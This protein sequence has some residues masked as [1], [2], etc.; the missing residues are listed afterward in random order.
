MDQEHKRTDQEMETEN[1]F[2][3]MKLMLEK[4][5]EFGTCADGKDLPPGIENEFLKHIMEFEKQW[6]DAPMIKIYDKVGRPT[7]F[8]PVEAIDEENIGTAWQELSAYLREHGISLDACSPNITRRELYRFATQELFELEVEDIQIPGL[9]HGFIYDEFHPDPVYDN[10]CLA[11][12]ECMKLIFQEAPLEW[13][14]QFSDKGIRLNTKES[15]TAEALRYIINR[16]KTVY[17]RIELAGLNC[18]GCSVMDTYSIVQGTY[19][20]DVYNGPEKYR[21]EG[22]WEVRLEKDM[23]F[24]AW[25]IVD[26]QIEG[27]NF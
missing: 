5:A 7:E 6:E 1:E 26:I 10:T 25:L 24:E 11:V 19:A 17:D 22:K 3:K 15:L 18:S 14:F 21:M 2:L 4:G 8:K 16:F 13:T 27:I 23:D 12:D 20:A 9:M